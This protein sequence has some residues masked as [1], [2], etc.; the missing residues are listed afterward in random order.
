MVAD[1]ARLALLPE[2]VLAR[3]DVLDAVDH[4]GH[5]GARGGQFAGAAPHFSAY[6]T[7]VRVIPAM[8]SVYTRSG[9][10]CLPKASEVRMAILRQASTPSMS[11]EGSFSA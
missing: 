10:T 2:E 6:A 3:L 5:D 7:S 9:S 11:A 8:P 1:I 4:V